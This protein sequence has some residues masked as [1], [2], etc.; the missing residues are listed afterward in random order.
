MSPAYLI[1]VIAAVS[2]LTLASY[3]HFKKRRNETLVC[4]IETTCDTVIHS[5]YSRFM[6]VPVELLGIVYYT[7]IVISYILF[8]TMPIATEMP[9]V[10][11]LWLS[12]GAF[13]FSLY[14]TSVQAFI[15]KHWCTWCLI[16]AML[17]A[18]IFF[19]AFAMSG[20]TSTL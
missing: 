1:I 12:G 9:R 2:G 14:L 11:L 15:L 20:V 16:S 3:I 8:L 4:P 7:I 13:L 10:T 6:H 19:S 17:C 18:I 5:D